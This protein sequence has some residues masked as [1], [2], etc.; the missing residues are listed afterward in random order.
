M[1]IDLTKFLFHFIYDELL[2]FK[3]KLYYKKLKLTSSRPD[4]HDF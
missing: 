1:D 3:E 2:S 4:F